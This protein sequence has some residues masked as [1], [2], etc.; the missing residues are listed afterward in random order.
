M[1]K[2]VQYC[3]TIPSCSTVIGYKWVFK[4]KYNID[5][6]IQTF[7]A[8]LVVKDFTKKKSIDYFDTYSL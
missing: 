4:R 7:K 6:S 5:G 3:L 2:W 8:R 1:M